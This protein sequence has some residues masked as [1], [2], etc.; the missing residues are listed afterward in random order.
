MIW[1]GYIKLHRKMME[2]GWYKDPN[3]KAV[4]LHLLLAASFRESTFQGEKLKPGQ[5]IIGRKSLAE[6]LGIS[7]QS[8]RTSI[9]RLKST[10]EITTKSTNR[11]TVVTITNWAKYQMPEEN[12]P[13]EQPTVQPTTNQQL[14]NNQPHLKNVKNVKNEKNDYYFSNYF[15]MSPEERKDYL[16]R[17]SDESLEGENV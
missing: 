5:V 12:Q 16:K 15:N 14:T 13:T 7:E 2:W 9:N 17:I 11:Y 4:F 8:V 10:N 6:T 1:N 3:T